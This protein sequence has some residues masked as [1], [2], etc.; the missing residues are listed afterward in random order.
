MSLVL[1]H[2]V[3][4]AYTTKTVVRAFTVSRTLAKRVSMS[5][6]KKKYQH[7]KRPTSTKTQPPLTLPLQTTHH[8]INQSQS[9]SLA[10][11]AA[12]LM[13]TPHKKVSDAAKK[14]SN[15]AW[16]TGAGAHAQVQA[17]PK[18]KNVTAKMTIATEKSMMSMATRI[19]APVFQAQKNFASQEH[20]A[21]SDNQTGN[22]SVHRLVHQA[23]GSARELPS[24]DAVKANKPQ[25]H[26]S[27]MAK[28]MTVMA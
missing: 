28:T 22:T 11:N 2:R 17:L 5:L 9:V 10:L 6:N 16:P 13:A 15:S 1:V 12:A 27:A 23:F 7:R 21:V 24:G 25:K 18:K 4:R 8:L 20:K 3:Y 26:K 19:V 14:A